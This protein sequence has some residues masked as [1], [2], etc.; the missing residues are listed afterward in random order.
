MGF[1][2]G[3]IHQ[4]LSVSCP[5]SNSPEASHASWSTGPL[6]VPS[7]TP[8]N[9]TQHWD[10]HVSPPRERC[11]CKLRQGAGRGAP[12]QL[13]LRRS[14]SKIC[15][16]LSIPSPSSPTPQSCPG[17]CRQHQ[18]GDILRLSLHQQHRGYAVC[19]PFPFPG[20]A[21]PLRLGLSPW[22]CWGRPR[23]IRGE[24]NRAKRRRAK[25]APQSKGRPR[26]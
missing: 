6:S 2:W 23:K 11:P 4:H 22:S 1:S 20:W 3:S 16:T 24:L 5:L 7:A 9:G 8:G 12:L 25:A 14:V 19:T 17:S 15:R 26:W 13:W 21:G 18:H 10:P